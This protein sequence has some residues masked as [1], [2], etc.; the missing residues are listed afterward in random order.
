METTSFG[1]DSPLRQHAVHN[2]LARLAAD[3]SP[4]G[5]IEPTPVPDGSK[6]AAEPQ[7]SLAAALHH[8]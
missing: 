1:R 2:L 6:A 7:K 4:P 3:E 8:S 5:W